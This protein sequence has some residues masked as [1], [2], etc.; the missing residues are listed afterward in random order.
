M[1]I[2]LHL[3]LHNNDKMHLMALNNKKSDFKTTLSCKGPP[4]RHV[5][6]QRNKTLGHKD[7]TSRRRADF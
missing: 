1:I 5:A 2:N 7:W 4:I 3:I 6:G